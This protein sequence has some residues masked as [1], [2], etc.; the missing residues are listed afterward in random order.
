M[1]SPQPRWS[2]ARVVPQNQRYKTMSALNE[3]T[4]LLGRGKT[5]KT[6]NFRT[7]LAVAALA[8]TSF[9]IGVA[10]TLDR[11]ARLMKFDRGGVKKNY[12]VWMVGLLLE[13]D[14]VALKWGILGARGEDLVC[15]WEI[16]ER[17][18]FPAKRVFTAFLIKACVLYPS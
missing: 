16:R 11:D 8:A 15:I 7:N 12:L 6:S 14:R 5:S 10:I 1:P 13:R 9:L 2:S 4:G 17:S 3:E 18:A